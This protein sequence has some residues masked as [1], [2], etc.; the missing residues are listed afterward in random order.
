M[1]EKSYVLRVLMSSTPSV[2]RRV[3]C[4]IKITIIGVAEL[5]VL[6]KANTNSDLTTG[7]IRIII[8]LTSEAGL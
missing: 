4:M 2:S 3:A 7:F 5:I 6:L 8:V 1:A